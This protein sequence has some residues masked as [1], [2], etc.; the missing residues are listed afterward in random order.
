MIKV[1]VLSDTHG[2]LPDEVYE[3]VSGCDEIWHAGDIGNY[4]VIKKLNRSGA[5]VR[6][7]YGNIDGQDIRSVLP[8][9][10]TFETCG[11]KVVLMHIGGTPARYSPLA[12][13]LI[14]K[15]SPGIFVCGHSHILKV[16]YDK[17]NSL[18][19]INPGAAGRNGF[20]KSITAIR[21]VLDNGKAKDMEVL[22]VKR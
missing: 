16:Q 7:V 21:F 2:I 10:E 4:E 8:E 22:D 19:Y 9:V 12:V 18:L 5:L 13:K 11:A 14:K 20:H 1:G 17:K 6:A 15:Y 3:F